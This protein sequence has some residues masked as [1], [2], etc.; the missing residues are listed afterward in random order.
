M[1]RKGS[2]TRKTDRAGK[3]HVRSWARPKPPAK[4]MP[5]ESVKPKPAKPVSERE[6]VKPVGKPKPPK[7]EN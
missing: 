2:Q 1:A 6:P 7:S 3:E 5:P 4:I